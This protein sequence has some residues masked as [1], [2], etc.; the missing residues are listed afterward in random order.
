VL[1]LDDHLITI[2]PTPNRGDCLSILGV[3]REVSA[4]TGAPMKSQVPPVVNEQIADRI[5]IEVAAREACPRYTARIVRGVNPRAPSPRWLVQRLER[6][7][8]R[9]ISAIVDVTNYVMLELGQPLHAFDLAR[10]EGGIH[11]RMAQSGEPLEVLNGQKPSLDATCLVIADRKKALA[12]A[13]IMGGA[14]SGVADET[15][16]ILLESAFFSPEAIAGKSRVLG[17]GSDSAYRFER[18]VDFAATVVALDRATQL[19]LDICGGKAGPVA[20]AQSALPPRL[21]VRMRRTRAERILGVD[22][23][24]A[25]VADIFARLG[26]EF[27]CEADDFVVNPP[28]YRFDLAIEE[29][30]IEEVA[31]VRGYE[32]IPETSPRGPAVILPATEA[33]EGDRQLRSRL[34]MRDYQEI[35]TYSFVDTV[36]ERDFG[37]GEPPV[38]LANPIAAH[39][40]VMRSNMLGS[41][42]D[43]LKLNLSRQQER[44]RLFEI[45]C[46]YEQSGAGYVQRKTLGGIAYGGA[47]SEQWGAEK[48]TVDFYDVKSD[49]EAL[50]VGRSLAFE[51]M[52]RQ[53]LH[54]GRSAA[55]L[56]DGVQS[57]FLGQLHPALQQKYN[58]PYAPICF[59]LNLDKLSSRNLTQFKEFSRQPIVRRDIAV[60]VSERIDIDALLKAL[61][62]A[63]SALVFDLAPFDLYRGKGIDSDKK[64]VAFRVLLQDTSKTLTDAEVDKEIGRLVNV[65]Q[66]EFQA[67]LR[68]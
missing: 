19:I 34:V 38:Q 26:Y 13:G 50:V 67:R 47:F 60:E 68:K 35:I 40:S 53:A 31:R 3:A 17:F 12:L 57:G 20:E 49:I 7:G 9:G 27:R 32:R 29:D 64:S 56:I 37:V 2:K 43:C 66:E 63:A 61:R 44:V 4:M 46:C 33:R 8:L 52:S 23:P 14:A 6:S 54:P 1:D 21:P 45:G 5:D 58:F 55:I 24:Q 25:E 15:Q 28:S 18:G 39:L 51:T 16:D 65:L 48:R 59:E 30:L 11:V 42:V 36:W 41:L 22:L 62:K 10:I